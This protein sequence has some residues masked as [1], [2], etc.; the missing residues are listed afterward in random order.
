MYVGNIAESDLLAG[1]NDLVRRLRDAIDGDHEPSEV[2]AL[3]ARIEAEILQLDASERA[4]FLEE[5]GL[6]L[7]W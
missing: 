7:N 1:E 3:S 5:L 6:F 2:V 4:G